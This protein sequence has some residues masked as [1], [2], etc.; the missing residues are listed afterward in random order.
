MRRI[1]S[2]TVI[3]LLVL[4]LASAAHA[5]A[6]APQPATP[7]AAT[8]PMDRAD[9]RRHIYVMEGALARAV[10][11]GAQ[12]LNRE[13][14]TVMPEMMALSGD[15]QARGVYLEGYGIYFDVAVPVLNQVMMWSLRTMMGP[16]EGVL[17]ALSTLKSYV[18]KEKLT[19]AT[20]TSLE[21]MIERLELQ[22]G[23][24]SNASA[25]QIAPAAPRRP[26]A[27][28][29]VGA[30]SV[31]TDPGTP[32]PSKSPAADPAA[33]PAPRFDRKNLQD[34]NAINRAYTEAVQNALVDTILDYAVA[35]AIRPDEF[36]T[37]AARDNMQ[38]DTLA[39]LDPYEEVVTVLL[40][41]KGS[42]LAAF[43]SGQIDAAEAR[44][45]VE[46]REF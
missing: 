22:L 29:T 17:S 33:T 21:A 35:T 4:V 41:I 39:P 8:R 27:G 13:I 5:Q 11:F 26:N 25:D 20:R 31:L 45:R 28:L 15:P 1:R 38:R 44:R 24:L 36:L 32:E 2:V 37:V 42:D 12:Q 23:P 16:D 34:P 43:R 18:Q 9:L 3:A 46:I 19:P 14:R 10:A 7:P 40:R 6:P 30:A